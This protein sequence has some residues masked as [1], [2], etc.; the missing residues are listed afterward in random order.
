[1]KEGEKVAVLCDVFGDLVEN[2]YLFI[3]RGW[4]REGEGLFGQ[5]T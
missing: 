3:W 2:I 4:Q 1:M 5:G